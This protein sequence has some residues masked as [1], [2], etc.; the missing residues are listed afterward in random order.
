VSDF[1]RDS[2][3]EQAT[4]KRLEDAR[5]K[6]QVPRSQDLSVALAMLAVGAALQITSGFLSS[7]LTT[8]M[9]RG[10]SFGR[11]AAVD[12]SSMGPAFRAALF[13]AGWL[14]MPLFGVALVA[15]VIAPAAV[16]GFN[17]SPQ[18]LG[19]RWER[20]D[21]IAGLGRMFSARGAI[22]VVKGISRFAVLAIATVFVLRNATGEL[23][24]LGNEP[25][26]AGIAHAFSLAGRMVLT[27]ACALLLIA[28]IDVPLV[29]WRHRRDLRMSKQELREEHREAEG[30][31]ELKG[32]IRSQLRAMSRR[33][34]IQ[35]VPTADMVIVN[36]THYAVA[37]KY[38][39]AKMR[40]PV[41]VAKG[42]DAVA[43]RIRA[44]AADAN[45][46]IVE[47]PPLARA[48]HA[49]CDLGDEI[50]PRLYVAVAQVL[51]YVYQVRS[52]RTAG[53]PPPVPPAFDAALD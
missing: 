40:A 16:G 19:F 17:F 6:G 23:L 20:L 49:G 46:P 7:T 10:L 31:P 41:V 32:H 42:V 13:T 1:D 30:N 37:V 36:P 25:T 4:P 44:V 9:T 26:M 29:I 22:E 18:A 48:L 35:A 34:M 39:A 14:C 8:L 2:R 33:R 52:L 43:A 50:P 28:A 15:A 47:A 27:L 5:R 53:L 51:S 21:P 12:P 38:D 45:I 3:T 11:D 24:G